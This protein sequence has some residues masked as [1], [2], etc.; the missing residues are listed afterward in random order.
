M[1]CVVWE[2][3]EVVMTPLLFVGL[4]RMVISEEMSVSPGQ[5]VGDHPNLSA[6]DSISRLRSRSVYSSRTLSLLSS[7]VSPYRCQP[8][9]LL[10][11]N[12]GLRTV[13]QSWTDH[14]REPLS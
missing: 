6:L 9:L 4:L 11:T 8:H 12:S 13:V 10:H 1:L 3:G 14:V 2:E 7:T 5:T